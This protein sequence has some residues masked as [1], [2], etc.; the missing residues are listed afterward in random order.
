M[1]KSVLNILLGI[2][3]I[4]PVIAQQDASQQ[5]INICISNWQENNSPV[6]LI[7]EIDLE[8]RGSSNSPDFT[9]GKGIDEASCLVVGK[10]VLSTTDSIKLGTLIL[11]EMHD[12][13]TAYEGSPESS[14]WIVET[15]DKSKILKL[16]DDES[17]L[18]IAADFTYV[19]N[20]NELRC[21]PDL[22][23][24]VWKQM[25]NKVLKES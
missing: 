16:N 11:L 22:L 4:C 10:V 25:L 6:V 7:K 2:G 23:H 9:R 20:G 3:L 24:G 8:V 21:R 17:S 12:G 14:Y 15:S 5:N 19:W 18:Y 13:D 1:K